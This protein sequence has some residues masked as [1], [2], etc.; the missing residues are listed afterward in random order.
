VVAALVALAL[1]AAPP[2]VTHDTLPVYV[3]P[4]SRGG[5]ID[6]VWS[7]T[8]Q[9]GGTRAI[10]LGVFRRPRTLADITPVRAQMFAQ[11]TGG[12]LRRARLLIASGG[13]RIWA[14][15]ADRQQVCFVR[16]PLGGGACV[17]T[18]LD[19]AYPQV[20]PRRDVWG[21]VD[22]GATRVDVTVGRRVLRARLGSNAF[23]LQLPAYAVVPSRIVVH[24]RD[25]SRH[26]FD[27]K[28][29][30]VDEISPLPLDPLAP[31][32]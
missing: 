7:W 16:D 26:V 30:S 28:R 8:A 12:D 13:T 10:S 14:F 3:A 31:P 18:L 24:E 22:D 29:C 6:V 23:F 20:D 32:C 27:I 2:A 25:R 21:L 17:G 1:A 5:S 4:P 11:F 15:P 9:S 19:G